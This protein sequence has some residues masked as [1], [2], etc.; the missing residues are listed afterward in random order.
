MRLIRREGACE[1]FGRPRASWLT[2]LG[3]GGKL[4]GSMGRRF[5]T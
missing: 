2:V 1:L 3:A 4:S 5:W